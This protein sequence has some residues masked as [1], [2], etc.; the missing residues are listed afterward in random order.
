MRSGIKLGTQ[1]ANNFQFLAESSALASSLAIHRFSNVARTSF[2]SCIWIIQ[3]V[4]QRE[5]KNVLLICFFIVELVIISTSASK[6]SLFHLE[7]LS[8]LLQMLFVILLFSL[9]WIQR[10]LLLIMGSI[11]VCAFKLLFLF[12]LTPKAKSAQV[13]IIYKRMWTRRSSAI[14]FLVY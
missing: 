14:T 12:C 9:I 4:Q 2:L 1:F 8:F 3:V 5:M 13:R 6:L 11:I 10:G 7:I